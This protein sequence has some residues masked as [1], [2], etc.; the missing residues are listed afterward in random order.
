[1]RRLAAIV[2]FVGGAAAADVKLIGSGARSGASAPLTLN[3]AGSARKVTVSQ[4]LY[5]AAELA[6]P[7]GSHLVEVAWS[8]DYTT[9]S[10]ALGCAV[11]LW[12]K[13]V[14]AAAVALAGPVT[15]ADAT[16]GATRVAS[17][18]MWP[19]P[20]AM[21]FVSFGAI[22]FAYAGGALEVVTVADCR[23]ATFDGPILWRYDL[24]TGLGRGA[25]GSAAVPATLVARPPFSDRRPQTRFHALVPGKKLAVRIPGGGEISN[26]ASFAPAPNYLAAMVAVPNRY[27]LVNEG[28][29]GVG[30][31]AI[32]TPTM[33]NAAVT[34]VNAPITSLAG[35]ERKVLELQVTPAAT[36]MTRWSVRV[37]SDDPAKPSVSWNV[38]GTTQAAPAPQ[39]AFSHVTPSGTATPLAVGV[40][41][42]LDLPRIAG[43]PFEVLLRY[44]NYGSGPGGPLRLTERPGT[45]NLQAMAPA[46]MGLLES[47]TDLDAPVRLLRAPGSVATVALTLEIG[48]ASRGVVLLC[49][50]P[51]PDIAVYEVVGFDIDEIAI[52]ST[53]DVGRAVGPVVQD[54][55]VENPGE[56]TLSLPQGAIV[57]NPVGCAVEVTEQPESSVEPGGVTT[58][59]TRVTPSGSGR[60]KY[61]V[62]IPNNVEGADP[63]I[64]DVTGG[65]APKMQ[66]EFTA[67]PGRFLPE[68]IITEGF[69][70]EL[71]GPIID[72]RETGM[73]RVKDVVTYTVRNLGDAPLEIS[74]ITAGEAKS[75]TKTAMGRPVIQPTKLTVAPMGVETFTVGLAELLA[76]P[77]ND[78]MVF[79]M[80]I[81]SNDPERPKLTWKTEVSNYDTPFTDRSCHCDAAQGLPLGL[82]VAL[83]RRGGARVRRAVRGAR[84]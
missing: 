51:P 62:R 49:P 38:V 65:P 6:L 68:T 61:R 79:E 22:D 35:G 47:Q 76:D 53:V 80:T 84:E 32:T 27:E 3:A 45:M 59:G 81:A 5:S 57:E 83:L 34:L 1:M 52:D 12:L 74:A 26:G 9:G 29:D 25:I 50:V 82:L 31:T 4:H 48:A 60:W 73:E 19:V 14:P 56:G 41:T 2:L 18:Q 71:G 46:V 78:N 11:E 39:P 8:K 36:G 77:I 30:I 17:A 37:D 70:V 23:L 54:F 66:V 69:R 44:H 72:A 10:A 75:Q 7:Q 55:L 43:V 63:F 40:E 24:A 21:G 20:A 33:M 42:S 58:F 67:G 16:S 15:L 28:L 13:N 64:F